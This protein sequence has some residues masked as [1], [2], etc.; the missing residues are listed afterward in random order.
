MAVLID[1]AEGRIALKLGE[2]QITIAHLESV[3]DQKNKEIEA[4]RQAA[5][6]AE[7]DGEPL[8]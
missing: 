7:P 6:P 2:A 3:I 1:S 8:A 5:A 4:L